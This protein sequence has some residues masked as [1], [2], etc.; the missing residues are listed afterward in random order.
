MKNIIVCFYGLVLPKDIERDIRTTV[1]DGLFYALD[2][3]ASLR[4]MEVWQIFLTNESTINISNIKTLNVTKLIFIPKKIW[5]VHLFLFPHVKK[6]AVLQIN[7]FPKPWLELPL[8]IISKILR[9][10][11]IDIMHNVYINNLSNKLG[12]LGK[13]AEIYYTNFYLKLVDCELVYTE[14][15]KSSI[16]KYVRKE[17]HVLPLGVT[18]DFL[19]FSNQTSDKNSEQLI[20]AYVGVIDP[21]KKVEDITKAIASINE[22]NRITLWII[23]PVRDQEYFKQ[24][25]DELRR[26]KVNYK[27]LGFIKH[28]DLPEVYKK[29]HLVINMC[30][31]EAFPRTF[32]EA[33]AC[34]T[35][36][37][38]NKNAY[39]PR[40]LIINEWNGYLV[41]DVDSL[42]YIIRELLD[43]PEKLQR[44]SRN[45]RAFVKSLYSSERTFE[46]L[47]VILDRLLFKT[48]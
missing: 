46:H 4:K 29:I 11:V 5:N 43:K 3:Y 23:G 33:M 16:K 40:T 2:K 36:V 41:N 12:F 19:E 45:C 42:S 38:G 14:Y 47:K 28:R 34:G 24:L 44:I 9:I 31:V 21:L 1:W 7:T 48:Q 10:K 25:K 27:F 32:L 30:P 39:G 20:V 22:R 37:I 13:L 17:L 35:P 15:A 6:I 18:N 8:V 26:G